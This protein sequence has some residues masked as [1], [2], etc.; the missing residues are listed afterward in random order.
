MA[1]PVPKIMEAPS[2]W[3]ARTTIR[4]PTLGDS[5]AARDDN[6]KTEIPQV[7]N[8]FLPYISASFPNG[9]RNVA[10]V[11]TAADVTHVNRIAFTE[12]SAPIEGNAI[13]TDDP[14]NVVRKDERK[15]TNRTTLLLVD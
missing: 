12:N 4:N 1:M 11:R 5:A 8:F 9:T 2:P 6:P 10:A 7:Y 15:V 14:M 3:K 13:L